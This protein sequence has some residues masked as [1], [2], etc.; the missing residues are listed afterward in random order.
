M[1]LRRLGKQRVETLQILR[2]LTFEDYGWRNHPAVTMWVGYTDALVAYGAAVTDAWIRAGFGDTV[3]PKLLEFL[4]SPPLRTQKELAAAG[5]LPPWIGNRRLHRSHQAAL[6]RKD[7]AHY[8]PLFPGVDPALP[9]VWPESSPAPPPS[10][11]VTAW[12]VRM[13]SDLITAARAR[14][15]VG[16]AP[17]PGEGPA[18]RAG[19]GGR[20]TKRRRQLVTFADQ[21]K[22]GDLVVVPVDDVL[23]LAEIA[24]DYEWRDDAPDGL[25]HI[26]PVRW[27]SQVHRA[28]LR[29]PVH[30]QDPRL[31]FGL[32]GEPSLASRRN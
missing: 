22:T 1:D 27:I 11:P 31:V 20:N 13:P 8:G 9:Y 4:G 6:V 16:L 19:N 14:N 29:R 21:L 32:R 15:V 17:L 30:L 23:L 18:A 25:Q 24:G 3:L 26:R 2:A 28:Q 10:Q 5:L 7:P 12:V